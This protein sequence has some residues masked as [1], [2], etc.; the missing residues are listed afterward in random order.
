MTAPLFI[1]ARDTGN[2]ADAPDLPTP[3]H[4]RA[5]ADVGALASVVVS[6][7]GQ[8]EYTRLCV[9]ALLRHSRP[10]LELL[11]LDAG[12]LDGTRDFLDGVATAAGVPVRVV[13]TA[14]GA[15]AA[16][17][18]DVLAVGGD[19]VVLLDN[20][21]LVTPGWL[22][23]LV[24]LAGLDPQFGLVAPSSNTAPPP[25]RVDDVP[26]QLGPVKGPRSLG[27]GRAALAE[28][29][30]FA[31]DWSAAR[32]GRWFEVERAGSGCVLLRRE[33]LQTLGLFPTRT[34]LGCFD[35]DGLAGRV[36]QAGYKLAGSGDVFV[37]HFGSRAALPR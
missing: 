6:C 25:L 2:G 31:R 24:R 20:D 14:A 21:V 11:C 10:P 15:G 1:H 22:E 7:C 27:D 18:G 35:T 26:Y 16:P 19:F 4:V 37:H 17:E 29:E 5:V 23:R 33:V 9:A 8:L 30:Q 3:A 12:S 36:R 34:A 32:R 28:V 13:R